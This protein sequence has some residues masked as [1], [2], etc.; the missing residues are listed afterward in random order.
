MTNTIKLTDSDRTILNALGAAL[1]AANADETH[2]MQ[3][4]TFGFI[5]EAIFGAVATITTR[6][7]ATLDAEKFREE[8]FSSW[9]GDH[10]AALVESLLNNDDIVQQ[11]QVILH[12]RRYR[13]VTIDRA[14]D[15]NV[16]GKYL[17]LE[18]A[19]R[20]AREESKWETTAV[21]Q[22]HRSMADGSVKVVETIDGEHA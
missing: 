18:G 9:S 14:G 15:R 6:E 7:G 10:T 11:A 19:R 12:A 22:I 1:Y 16:I 8:F 3:S 2:A 17:T 5:A 4:A 21:A 13:V 20:G